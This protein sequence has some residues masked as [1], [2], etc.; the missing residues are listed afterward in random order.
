MAR[1]AKFRDSCSWHF[2]W[3]P[4]RGDGRQLSIQHIYGWCW[5]LDA[6][7]GRHDWRIQW[8]QAGFKERSH[9]PPAGR[10]LVIEHG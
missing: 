7:W 2:G 9:E 5:N 3:Y 4:T 8:R 10:G 1:F 6:A